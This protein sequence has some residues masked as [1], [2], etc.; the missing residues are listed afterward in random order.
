M[1]KLRFLT[2]LLLLLPLLSRA[3][4][5]VRYRNLVMEG[6]GI[7]GIAYGGALQEL[8]QQGVL[9]GIQR[10]GGTSAGAIQAALLAVGYSASEIISI[11]NSTPVQRLN[12]GRFIFVGG[13]TR[14]LK[15]YGWYRGDEFAR[16]LSE[17][18]GRKTG[19]P[20]L[21]LAELHARAGK[22]QGR[23]L[24]VTGT[25]LTKQ[26]LEVISYE[27][28]PRLRVA[29][30]V[31][32]SMSIPLYFRAVLL[33]EQ[34][35]V[36]KKP[37]KNQ[38]VDVLVDGGLLANYPID[39]FDQPRF[40]PAGTAPAGG[41]W[42]NPETLGLRL[43]RPEQIAYDVRPGGRQQLAP[44]TIT[45]F[46]SYVGALYTVAIENLNPP[47]PED[48]ARTISI[49]TKGFNPRIKR[50]SDAQKQQLMDSGQQGVQEFFR[51]P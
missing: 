31:R 39:L 42:S 22:G 6:G 41:H 10:V 36:V 26:R 47:R 23:D 37:A 43:D 19:N 50:V 38:A 8:E 3:Q 7:R 30:A 34:G 9:A 18:V 15:Q 49:S 21:T 1:S 32:I 17:L 28:H 27:T 33:D 40:L 25:N 51:R 44:Y 16:Y 14:V 11:V 35:Q 24:Y 12:D 4:P 29:D 5:P 46:P 45:N 48:W 20:N 2:C 13:S